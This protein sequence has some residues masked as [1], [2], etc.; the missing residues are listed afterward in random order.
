MFQILPAGDQTEVGENGVTLSGGQKARIAL[1]RAVY[2]EKELYLL[3]D[4]LA[5]VDANVANHLMEKCVMGVLK[6]KTRILCTHRTEFLKK[7]DALLLVDN[8]RVVRTGTPAEILPLVEAFPKFKDMD[9]RQDKAPE[10]QGQEDAIKTEAEEL[11]PN[12][13]LLRQEEEKKE[14]AVAF[15]VYKAYWLAVGSCLASSI[16]FSLLLMQ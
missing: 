13:P 2:Q 1:A 9:K 10:E 11:T 3:D 8:G 7:A 5:A 6:H 16:L 14:G 12:N 4:P 15:K